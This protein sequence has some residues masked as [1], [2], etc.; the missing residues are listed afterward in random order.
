MP[1]KDKTERAAYTVFQRMR[2]RYG[3]SLVWY[4]AQYDHQGGRCAVCGEHEIAIKRGTT[5]RLA[6]DHNHKTGAARGLLC[7]QCNVKL[8]WLDN[9]PAGAVRYL[10]EHKE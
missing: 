3:V 1:H 8:A 4:L 2:Y 10:S 7:M 6:I 5:Q 9:P